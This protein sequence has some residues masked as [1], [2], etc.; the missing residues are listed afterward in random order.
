MDWLDK[1]AD[2]L[3]ALASEA[4]FESASGLVVELAT[5]YGHTELIGPFAKDTVTAFNVIELLRSEEDPEDEQ[6]TYSVRLLFP[7]TFARIPS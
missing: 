6:N 5:P 4:D 3:E 7:P 1:F 2:H